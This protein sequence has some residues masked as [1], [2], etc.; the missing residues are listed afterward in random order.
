MTE[1]LFNMV[2]VCGLNHLTTYG[3]YL[4]PYIQTARKDPALLKLL[5]EMRS[6]SYDG[7]PLTVADDDWCFENRISMIDMYAATEMGYVMATV[8]G[9][10]G[11]FIHPL[12]GISYRFDPVTDTS[13][14]VNNPTSPQLLEFVVLADSPQIPPPHLVSSDGNFRT[15]DLFEKQPDGSYLYRG[16]DDDWIKSFDSDRTDAKAIEQKVLE[17]CHDLV[18]ECAVVGHLRPSPA[19]FV[20][21]HHD[22]SSM[23]EDSVK[24][25]MLRR[26][27]DFNA[28]QYIHEAITE[29][30]LI[31]IINDGVLPRT[32]K[33]NVRRKVIEE[34]Y[35]KELDAMYA[36]VYSD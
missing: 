4:T 32:M 25:L 33:G 19:L 17:T 35:L 12:P 23:S 7:V 20:V 29:K 16:R 3:T 13:L 22:G 15:G 2:R 34:K 24:E 30:Q 28:R 26:I 27:E 18:K 36:S 31:F 5:Q 14:Q 11:R 6:V 8:P 10:P 9:K 21:L 1:E